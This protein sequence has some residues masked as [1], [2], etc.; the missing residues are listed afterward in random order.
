MSSGTRQSEPSS[1]HEK[2]VWPTL[3]ACPYENRC[4]LFVLL[5][6]LAFKVTAQIL[7]SEIH[8]PPVEEPA[9]NA[10]GTPAVDLT[11]DV[12]EFVE[13]QNAGASPV[14][15]AGWTLAGGISYTFPSDAAIA[16]GAFRGV[17]RRSVERR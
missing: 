11:E 12:Y 2:P 4:Y 5:S 17:A 16:P 13:I 8:Y 7:I 15:L 6:V 9:F 10:D 14:N 3:A 1:K